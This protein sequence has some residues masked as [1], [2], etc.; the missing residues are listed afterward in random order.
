MPKG[1]LARDSSLSGEESSAAFVVAPLKLEVLEVLEFRGDGFL[2]RGGSVRGRS[3]VFVLLPGWGRRGPPVLILL[4]EFAAVCPGIEDLGY[5]AGCVL[6]RKGLSA[7]AYGAEGID[8]EPEHC[9]R[10][11]GLRAF[12]FDRVHPR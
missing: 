10:V 7:L 6:L 4:P 5:T 2:G 8:E 12:L 1:R 11:D 9:I 3:K